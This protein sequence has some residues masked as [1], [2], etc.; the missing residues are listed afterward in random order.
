MVHPG[1]VEKAPGWDSFSTAADREA[2]MKAL[3]S[4]QVKALFQ[5][6]ALRLV[7][8]PGAGA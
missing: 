1:Y 6:H 2:E 4:P 5:A 7:T 8:Y 3:C